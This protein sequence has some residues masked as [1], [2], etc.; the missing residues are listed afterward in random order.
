MSPSPLSPATGDR[1]HSPV[2]R[3]TLPGGQRLEL[4]PVTSADVDD[5]LRLHRGLTLDELYRRSH[6]V[7]RPRRE[8]VERWV[9]P[10]GEGDGGGFGVVATM[11]DPGAQ[12]GRTL[13]AG[14]YHRLPNGDG[15]LLLVV[16]PAWREWLGR[17]LLHAVLHE[18]G[19]R[20]VPNLEMAIR[21]TDQPTLALVRARGC[22][23]TPG[24]HPWAMRAVLATRGSL[25]TWPGPH[26]RPR[27]LVEAP[28]GRWRAADA[29]AAAGCQVLVCPGPRARTCPALGGPGC[30]L[31][32]AADAV[33][34][35]GPALDGRWAA[36]PAAHRTRHPGVPVCVAASPGAPG[37]AGIVPLPAGTIGTADTAA[38]TDIVR[39]V[40]LD[41]ARRTD[42]WTGDTSGDSA[43]DTAGDSTG[44]ARALAASGQS[45]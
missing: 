11:F 29:L 44:D 24:D 15:E 10:G 17:V 38:I 2:R 5:V 35:A 16:E 45:G 9:P 36:L 32:A 40:A 37:G 34:V 1:H 31:A 23:F 3:T 19:A 22:V 6:V 41:H 27:V 39:R 8:D 4:R 18:A 26:D 30:P 7:S 43:G 20:G 12:E 28:S 25:P 13:G 21:L 42:G 14:G 33:V